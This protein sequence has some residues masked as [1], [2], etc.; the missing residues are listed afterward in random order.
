MDTTFLPEGGDSNSTQSKKHTL[1][2]PVV[3][4]MIEVVGSSACSVSGVLLEDRNQVTLP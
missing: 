4:S 1:T 3:A 2:Y